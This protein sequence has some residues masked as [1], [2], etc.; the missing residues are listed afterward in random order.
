MK[1]HF[2]G[3]KMKH[4]FVNQLMRPIQKDITLKL[5]QPHIGQILLLLPLHQRLS[6]TAWLPF[7]PQ[8]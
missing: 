2:F 5:K 7:S 4:H 1:R 3:K 6:L 8:L